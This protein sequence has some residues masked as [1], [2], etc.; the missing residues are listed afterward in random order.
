MTLY[1][2]KT[3]DGNACADTP[4]LNGL[5][6]LLTEEELMVATRFA[7]SA[8]SFRSWCRTI[9]IST[10][11]G[12]KGLYDLKLVRAR[13]DEVQNLVQPPASITPANLE[14]APISLVDE[15]RARRGRA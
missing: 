9:R 6:T 7:G 2:R 15:R 1:D 5:L 13:L 8:R 11:P 10:V 4:L 14:Q 3:A 12:R